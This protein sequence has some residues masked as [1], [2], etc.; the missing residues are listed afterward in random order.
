MI[1]SQVQGT[2]VGT[3]MHANLCSG[4]SFFVYNSV[5]YNSVV[6]LWM[7]PLLERA[8]VQVESAFFTWLYMCVIY[9]YITYIYIY[10]VYIYIYS[11][12]VYIYIQYIYI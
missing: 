8:L 10:S 4:L 1:L 6:S 11:V 12:Y 3:P 7:L 9:I 2:H 5:V